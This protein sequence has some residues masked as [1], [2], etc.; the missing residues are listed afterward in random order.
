MKK[1]ILF[2]MSVVASSTIF[3][4]SFTDDFESYA[5]GSYLGSSSADWTTWSGTE[6][7]AED[8]TINADNASSGSQSIYFSSTSA[9]GGP[10]DVV[11]PF[12]Q[13]YNSGNFSFEANFFVESGKGAY[14]NLQGT[15]VVAEIWAMDCYMLQDGTLK[16]SNQGTPYINANYPMAQWF[17]MR[18]EMDLTSN[19]WELYIDN[20][21]QGTFSNPTG[22]IGILDLYPVNPAGQGGNGV[23]GFYVDDISYTH[24]PANLPPLNGGVSFITQINGIAGLSYDVVATARNLGQFDINSFDLTY[25]YNGND[26]TESITGLNLVS[27]DTYEHTFGSQLTPVLGNNDLTVTISNVNGVTLDDDPSDD[28]KSISIDPIVPAAG[29]VV[30]GEEATGT[31]CQWCPRGAVYMDLFE[32][33]YQ[34]YWIGIAVH[35]GDPMTDATYD[36]GMGTLIGGYPSAIVDRGA[37]V[38]PSGMTAD[39]LERLQTDPAAVLL[40]GA[41]WDPATRVLEV[42]VKTTFSQNASNS[43]KVACALTEDGVTGTDGG[44]NQSNAYAGGGNGVMGGYEALP[45]P[46]PAAQMVYDHVARSIA[47]SFAGSSN[48]FPASINAGEDYIS[49]F[50]FTLPADWDENNMHIIGLL[51]DPSGRIDNGSSTSIST[52]VDNGYELG[53]NL[54]VG[55]AFDFNIDDALVIYPN[56]ATDVL[57]VTVTSLNDDN[58]GISIYNYAGQLVHHFELNVNN[59]SWNFEVDLST[60][61]KGLYSIEYKTSQ[62]KVIKKFVVQ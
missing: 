35:N 24:L 1:S 6:G 12:D 51:M 2:L 11:L 4:Q 30:V 19:V 32:E 23:S 33:T 43:Y 48:S 36:E 60:Y 7:G 46:V 21:S 41:T 45:N 56:P 20:I 8:V 9:N 47:P 57:N 37:D 53:P 14:F 52:A 10:Q 40:N 25:S 58:N 27:L 62:S 50:S 22:Q 49:N 17:N 38:D 16:L 5:V 15:L 13:V 42:S 44:Y 39:F 34:D 26:V 3:A 29:K 54:G 28:S 55:E 61:A 59:G 18:I 31:W